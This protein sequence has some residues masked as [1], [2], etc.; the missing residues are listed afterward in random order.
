MKKLACLILV[1]GLFFSV[2]VYSEDEGLIGVGGKINYWFSELSGDVKSSEISLIGSIIDFKNDLNVDDS[3]SVPMG[4]AWVRL[5]KHK[6][7]LGYTKLS[8]DGSRIT[9]GPLKYKGVTYDVGASLTSS[10]DTTMIDLLYERNLIS[11]LG[12]SLSVI[13]GFK[14]LGFDSELTGSVATVSTKLSESIDA[15]VPVVGLAASVSPIERLNV[16]AKLYGISLDISGVEATMIDFTAEVSYS[17]TENISVLAGYKY[18]DIDGS[19]DEDEANFNLS[20]FIIG[21]KGEF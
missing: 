4:E 3:E 17:I 20:G 14:V 10:L 6:I 5:G 15:P 18:F 19:N 7:S 13:G 16:G 1:I 12:N 8:F 9:T 21:V 2:S 11:G